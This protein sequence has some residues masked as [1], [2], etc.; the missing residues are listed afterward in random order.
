MALLAVVRFIYGA[1]FAIHGAGGDDAELITAHSEVKMKEPVGAGA[2]QDAETGLGLGMGR[3]GRNYER[4]VKEN[5]L[6]F[7][8]IY[9]V[10]GRTFSDVA[11]I[12]FETGVTIGIKRH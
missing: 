12:P 4:L 10:L 9:V 6:G 3:I 7:A 11:C 1:F 8:T 5:F 2:A